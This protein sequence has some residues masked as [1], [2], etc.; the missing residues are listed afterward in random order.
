[1]LIVDDP[2]DLYD[3]AMTDLG[4]GRFAESLQ[5]FRLIMQRPPAV[6]S[7]Y[8]P[9]QRSFAPAG[10]VM[11]A[12]RYPPADAELKALLKERIAELASTPN[13]KEFADDVANLQAHVDRL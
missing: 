6:D 11:L 12:G 8:R 3:R 2:M 7:F 9:L 5:N 1:M 13:D 10:W 4:E